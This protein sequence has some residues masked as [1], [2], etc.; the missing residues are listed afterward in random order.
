V[1]VGYELN[2]A[3]ALA[4]VFFVFTLL[5]TFLSLRFTSAEVAA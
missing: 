3:S 5:F 4:G 2:V 1:K